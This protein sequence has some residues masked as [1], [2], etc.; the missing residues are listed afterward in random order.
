M[1]RDPDFTYQCLNTTPLRCLVA[2]RLDNSDIGSKQLE[3]VDDLCSLPRREGLSVPALKHFGKRTLNL[4]F[5]A[6]DYGYLWLNVVVGS[7]P[8]WDCAALSSP[9]TRDFL[10]G[11]YRTRTVLR[12]GSALPVEHKTPAGCAPSVLA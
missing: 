10:N 6:L 9:N 7:H 1:C 11:G 2:R 8:V 5:V 12:I 4:I 3:T